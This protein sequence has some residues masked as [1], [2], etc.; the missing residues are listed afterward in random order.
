MASADS[1]R[2]RETI[3]KSIG[4]FEFALQNPAPRHT[5]STLLD[6][7]PVDVLALLGIDMMDAE[8]LYADNVTG[9]IVH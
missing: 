6:I 8:S 1:F 9:C 4:L 7:V 5:I 3:V 2:F